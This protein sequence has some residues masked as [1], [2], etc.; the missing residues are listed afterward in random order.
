MHIYDFYGYD[1]T[2]FT[3]L[4]SL[5]TITNSLNVLP[6]KLRPCGEI[7][8]LGGTAPLGLTFYVFIQLKEVK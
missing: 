1:S 3:A 6:L 4:V 5:W 2:D 8:N 7:T